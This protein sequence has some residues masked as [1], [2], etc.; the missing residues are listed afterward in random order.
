MRLKSVGLSCPGL[1]SAVGLALAATL[2]GCGGGGGAEDAKPAAGGGAAQAS[3]TVSGVVADGPLQG[4]S[5][6]LDTN[7]SGACDPGEP[8]SGSTDGDGRYSLSIPGHLVGKHALVAQVPATAIDKDKPG[9]PVGV[10]FTLRAPASSQAQVFVSPLTTL[11]ADAISNGVPA[12]VAEASIQQQLGLSNS[13]LADFT[14]V[15]DP[16]AALLARTVNTVMVEVARLAAAHGIPADQTQALVRSTSA[17][18]LPLL[19]ARVQAAAAQATGSASDRLL[20]VASQAASGVLAD[21]NISS[22]TVAA[23]A[24]IAK[25]LS[26]SAE[27]PAAATPAGP[28]TTVRRFVYKDAANYSI[29]L[30]TGDASITNAAGE[31]DVNETRIDVVAGVAQPFNRNAVWWTGSQWLTCD[32]G[33]HVFKAVAQTATEPQ[34]SLTCGVGRNEARIV[35]KDI[36]GRRMADVVAELRSFPLRDS[37]GSLPETWGPSPALLGDAVFPA[38]A[39]MTT[40][41]AISEIG[42][43]DMLALGSKPVLPSGMNAATLEEMTQFAGTYADPNAANSATAMAFLDDALVTPAQPGLAALQRYYASFSP[44]GNQLR[45]TRCDVLANG[46]NT[47]CVALGIGTV[48][49]SSQGDARIMRITSGYPMDLLASRKRQRTWIER[50]G[51][52]F[53][54]QNLLPNLHHNQRLNGVAWAA[55]RNRLG[56]P[57]HTEPSAPQRLAAF[58][59]VHSFAFTDSN[60]WRYRQASR[61]LPMLADVANDYDESRIITA[62]GV[63]RTN[64]PQFH[65]WTGSAWRACSPL[66]GPGTFNPG[67]NEEVRCDSLKRNWQVTSTT[68]D[69][70]FVSDVLREIRRYPGHENWGA[71]PGLHANALSGARFAAGSRLEYATQLNYSTPLMVDASSSSTVRVPPNLMNADS[72]TWPQATTLDMVVVA[73]TGQLAQEAMSGNQA[74][75]MS[76]SY[77]EAPADGSLTGEVQYRVSF[78]P[79]GNRATFWRNRV[80]AADNRTTGFVAL[81]STTFSIDNLGGQRVLRFASVPAEARDVGADRVLVEWS[82]GVRIGQPASQTARLPTLLRLNGPAWESVRVPLSIPPL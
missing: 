10:A 8:V 59:N 16:Q 6:C 11:V 46:A 15:A 55:L 4:A 81:A 60:N 7:D 30:L 38:G 20:Q 3:L 27:S 54:G 52:V 57:A 42:G 51:V 9:I 80:W 24:G 18:D 26:A 69:G 48:A 77:V 43:A 66:S 61:L 76:S 39:I 53:N 12:A 67:T 2:A 31:Y 33:W 58:T 19:A 56:I 74:L 45:F 49:T 44:N 28:D 68:L 64:H 14:R 70:R 36:S 75:F 62:Q 35:S 34:R 50:D 5:V 37:D 82:D 72:S 71:D 73:Y 23:Q 41:Q 65:A 25:A 13:P 21:R 40:R 29:Q 78:D 32:N 63:R 22:A 79:V 17:A 1:A 47:G